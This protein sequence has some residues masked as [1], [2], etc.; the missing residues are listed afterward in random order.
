MT[1]FP[2][3]AA[4]LVAAPAASQSP[5]PRGSVEA[6]VGS[7][8]VKID[9]GRPA[10]GDR[11]LPDL[12]AMLPE[13]RVWRAGE[14]QVTTLETSGDLLIGGQTVPAGRYSLYLHIADSGE[15]S[16]LVN[17]NLGIPLGEL[18]SQAPEAMRAEPWPAVAR[19]A[20]IQDEELARVPLREADGSGGGDVFDIELVGNVLRFAWGGS[21]YQTTVRA[22]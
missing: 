22:P 7:A 13:D 18:S 14:N 10:L 5:N 4:G 19:Y 8:T 1:W 12:L 21:A 15:W 2:L 16:L 9:H 3:L 6:A 17:R 11:M 20:T